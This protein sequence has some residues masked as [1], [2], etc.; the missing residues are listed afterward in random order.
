MR[1]QAAAAGLIV[2]AL[3]V[4]SCRKPD[5]S[6]VATFEGGEVRQADVEARILELPEDQRRPA[7]DQDPAAWRSRLVR[8][9]A[10]ERMLLAEAERAHAATDPQFAKQREA[11]RERLLAGLY[12]RKHLP[13]IALPTEQ[14]LRKY[15]EE[16]PA[17]FRRP[18]RREVY[19]I[20]KRVD[21]GADR[22]A[23][24]R[25]MEALRSR[26]L[27]GESFM[28]LA[29]AHSDSETRHKKGLWDW[30]EPGQ[31]APELEKVLFSLKEETPSQVLSTRDGLHLFWV[32]FS[33]PQV[34][35]DF[36]QA[37]PLAARMFLSEKADAAVRGLIDPHRGE[38][39]FVPTREELAT[40]LLG[41][42]PKTLVLRVGRDSLYLEELD[43]LVR[44]A[45]TAQQRPGLDLAHTIVEERYRREVGAR[46]AQAEGL[47][48]SP[49]F[50][51][52][53]A[54]ME[55]RALSEFELQRQLRAQIDEAALRRYFEDNRQRYAAPMLVRVEVLSLPLSRSAPRHMAELERARSELDAGRTTLAHLAR[56]LGGEVHDQGLR[57]LEQVDQAVPGMSNWALELKPGTHSAPFRTARALVM[58]R[59]VSRRDPG[60]QG[61]EAARPRVV[62]DYLRQH[63]QALR[64]ALMDRWLRE[65]RFKEVP[66][67]VPAAASNSPLTAEPDTP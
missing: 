25:E 3:G 5:P 11:L 1:Q 61:F 52:R 62:E 49:E 22:A 13:K 46:L 14:D 15:Y 23:A 6:V 59:L 12:I 40:L 19:T 64:A 50:A 31:V 10:F 33:E 41:G 42:G 8:D 63:G 30:I 51:E 16:H 48:R 26:V 56:R 60:Q 2:V 17:V 21:K 28:E 34:Q 57:T 55:S 44:E 36:D 37:R 38:D 67:A 39:S 4:A 43:Q 29:A 32:S 20:F 9:L 18:A 35:L 27:A 47:D 65:R 58:A 54:D 53:S 45:G 66:A 24:R 7:K